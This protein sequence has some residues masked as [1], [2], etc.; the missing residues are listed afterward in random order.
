MVRTAKTVLASVEALAS[1][2]RGGGENG[3]RF[4]SSGI[5]SPETRRATQGRSAWYNRSSYSA[6][7][8]SRPTTVT[9]SVQTFLLSKTSVSICS[10]G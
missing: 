9:V 7:T 6:K 2:T 3:P 4:A 10:A 5:P 8:L 1:L